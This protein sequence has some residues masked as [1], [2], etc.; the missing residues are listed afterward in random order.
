VPLGVAPDFPYEEFSFEMAPG[1]FMTL[2]TDG[3]SEAM[4]FDQQ[5]YGLERIQQ[6]MNGAYASVP[7]LG[8]LILD[9][10][11]RFVGQ[12]PQSDDMCLMCVGR[13]PAV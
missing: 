11:K 7:E 6:Q 12:T 10:V 5:L 4:N 2:F 1:E 13:K 8:K 9:D 3:I